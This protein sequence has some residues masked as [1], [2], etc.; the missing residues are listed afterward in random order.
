MKKPPRLQVVDQGQGIS[1]LLSS[2]KLHLSGGNSK[3]AEAACHHALNKG[4]KKGYKDM[5]GLFYR[6]GTVYA[7]RGKK[8]DAKACYQEA[9]RL[10]P[11]H[12]PSKKR[13]DRMNKKK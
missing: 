13:L 9:L 2:C 6:L 5:P 8:D 10:N 11:E 3:W 7:R 12:A 1:G 4:L